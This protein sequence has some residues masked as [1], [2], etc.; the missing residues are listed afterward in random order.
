[1]R[2]PGEARPVLHDLDL[3]LEAGQAIGVSGRSGVGKSTLTHAIAGL[4]PWLRPA[5]V[6][7]E[8]LLDGE[9][10]D[11]LDP[12]Q[13]AHLFSTCL[14]RPDAQLFLPTVE[15]ELAAVFRPTATGRVGGVTRRLPAPRAP[16]RADG[17]PR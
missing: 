5:E 12:G 11:D 13:R 9:S 1:V 2:L 3:V 17:P 10:V 4:V 14:D 16:R 6:G 8:V 15:Q 7:G